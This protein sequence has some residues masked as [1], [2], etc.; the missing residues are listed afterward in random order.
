MTVHRDKVELGVSNI[1]KIYGLGVNAATFDEYDADYPELL[2]VVDDNKVIH[3]LKGSTYGASFDE[4][5]KYESDYKEANNE[6]IQEIHELRIVGTSKVI[7]VIEKT[8][9][10]KFVQ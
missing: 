1:T 3:L 10:G 6:K 8:P 5:I 2:L 7:G 4:Y 9:E